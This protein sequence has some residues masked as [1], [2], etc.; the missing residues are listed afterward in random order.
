MLTSLELVD[1]C[2]VDLE[3]IGKS[4]T[5]MHTYD[6]IGQP[7]GILEVFKQTETRI[8]NCN[9]YLD[10]F[11]NATNTSQNSINYLILKLKGD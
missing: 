2:L 11:P 10:V 9:V 5:Y 6:T 8:P 3:S 4:V 7:D 1:L